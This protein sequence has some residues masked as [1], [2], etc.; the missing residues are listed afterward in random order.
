MISAAPYGQV[1]I[2]AA[3]ISDFFGTMKTLPYRLTTHTS[4][5]LEIEFPLRRDAA[6]PV[7]TWHRYSQKW[8]A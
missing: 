3:D 6:H 2:A 4:E 1:A 5:A 8:L 7:R